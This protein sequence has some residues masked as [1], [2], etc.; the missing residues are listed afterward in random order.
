MSFVPSDF[1]FDSSQNNGDQVVFY[2]S[3]STAQEPRFLLISRKRATYNAA[4]AT[5]S[6]PEY[7]VRIY[8]GDVDGDGIPRP[9]RLLA[10]LSIGFPVWS[11]PAD[12]SEVLSDLAAII[13]SAEFAPAVEALSLPNCCSEEVVP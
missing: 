2:R 3:N 8:V 9:E 4:S 11:D 5:W 13:N 6:K 12:M 1:E 7:R 10:D